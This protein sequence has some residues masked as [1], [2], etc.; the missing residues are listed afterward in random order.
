MN[1]QKMTGGIFVFPFLIFVVSVYQIFDFLSR[2][3]DRN[4]CFFQVPKLFF[5]GLVKV[6]TSLILMNILY[7][8]FYNLSRGDN[9]IIFMYGALPQHPRPIFLCL[10]KENG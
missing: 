2:N 5:F 6:Q 8:I 9:I 1:P 7:H 4:N 3:P 10:P